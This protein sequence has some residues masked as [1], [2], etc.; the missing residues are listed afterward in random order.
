MKPIR[1]L[2]TTI[3]VILSLA[4][5]NA[6]TFTSNAAISVGNTTYDG[7]DII[8][9]GCTLTVDGPHAFA[10]LLV[11]HGGVLTHSSAPNGEANN[12]V[13]L[14]IVGNAT[15]DTTSSINVAGLGYA[16]NKGPGSGGQTNNGYAGG[17][18]AG[19]GG[20]ASPGSGGG[21]VYGSIPEPG[22]HGSGGNSQGGAGGGIIGLAVGGTLLVDGVISANG[23]HASGA[24]GGGGAGGSVLLSA[25]TLAGSGT[26]RADGGNSGNSSSGGGGG[27]RL[28]LLADTLSFSGNLSA[29]GG[30]GYQAGGAGTIFTRVTTQTNGR[31]RVDNAGRSGYTRVGAANWPT[32]QVYELSL[33]GAATVVVSLPITVPQLDI[34]GGAVLT[35]ERLCGQPLRITVL[36]QATISTGASINVDG[37]GYYNVAWNQLDC[38]PGVGGTT[39]TNGII[40]GGGYGGCGGLVPGITYGSYQEP[41][42]FGSTATYN[43]SYGG[44]SV[45]LAVAGTLTVDGSISAAGQTGGAGGSIFLTAATLAGSGSIHADGGNAINTSS[46][47][48]GGGRVALLA[49]A[50]SFS[51]SLTAIGGTGGPAGGAGTVYTRVTAQTYGQLS[52]DNAGRSGYT[53]LNTSIWPAGQVCALRIAGAAIVI[54]AMPITVSQLDITTG[55]MLTHERLGGQ[56]LRITVL[57]QATIGTGTSI[58]VDGAGYYSVSPSQ[59]DRGPGVGGTTGTNGVIGGGGYGGCGGLA[60]G[61]TYGTYQEPLEFGSAAVNNG[62]YGGG[63]VR[64]A[65][66]G[67]LTVDGSISAGGQVGGA[68]GSIFLTAATLAGGGAIRADGGNA[69]N[70]SSG[71]GG[72]GRVALLAD[73]LSFSGNLTAIGGTGGPAGGA[74]TVFTQVT[75]EAYGQLRLDNAGRSGYTRLNA[76]NWPAGQVC[77]LRIAGAAIVIPAMPISVSQLDIATGAMLTHERLA[78]QPLRITVLGSATIGSGA[79]INV[80]AAGYYYVGWWQYNRGPGAGGSTGTNGVNGGA[81]YG[82]LG[83]RAPGVT[84]GSYQEPLDF[85]SASYE[86]GSYGGGSVRL[87]VI[88]TLTVD[89]TV[90]ACGQGGGASGGSV[91][92]ACA[93]FAGGGI[94]Q[95]NGSAAGNT[96]SGGGGGGRIAI[97]S[98]TTS[99]LGS[100]SVTGGGGSSWP[101]GIGTIYLS[102]SVPP[103]FTSAA[104]PS[105]G[106]VGS[107]YNHTCTASGSTPITFTVSAGTLPTGLTLGT[108]GM[109]TGTPDASGTFSGT[110]TAAN[111]TLPNATQNFSIT[112]APAPTP[113]QFTS[114]PPPSSGMVGIA[115]NHTCTASGTSPITFTV[116]AGAL[117]TGLTMGTGGM[118]TGTPGTAGTFS[119]TI[120]AANG[121]QP[122][123]TQSF[124]ITIAPAPLAPQF[125]STA[126]PSSGMVGTAYNHTC[127]ASGSTPVTFSVSTGALPGGLILGTD[128]VIYGTP[129]ATG[130]FIGTITAA[131][132]TQPNATQSFSIT[133]EPAPI[134]PTIT[135]VSPLP[136]GTLGTAYTQTL[137][138]TG[139]TTPYTWTVT[140]GNLPLGLILDN[141]VITG[142]PNTAGSTTFSV[143]VKGSNGASSANDLSLTIQPASA[144]LRDLTVS[145]CVLTP[146]FTPEETSYTATTYAADLNVTP[147]TGNTGAAIAVRCN[148]GEWQPAVSGV[149]LDGLILHGGINTVETRVTAV[150]GTPIKTYAVTITRW[151]PLIAVSAGSNPLVDDAVAPLDFGPATSRRVATQTLTI[152]N[153]G[154]GE[155]ILGSLSNGGTNASDFTPSTPSSTTLAPGSST[156]LTITF[157][158][159]GS[160]TRTA[161]IHLASNVGGSTNPFDV[162]LTGMGLSYTN[163]TDGD[164]MS[165][166]AEYD[167]AALGFDWQANQ[168]ELV[169]TLYGG[170]NGAGLYTASQVET[171]SIG[172]PLLKRDPLSGQFKLTLGLS[173]TTNLTNFSFFPIA[174]PQVTINANGELELRFDSEDAAAFFR[175]EAK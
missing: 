125:T 6:T 64:L 51:G 157:N 139:G 169:A 130:T 94:I 40:G 152:S 56:P 171:L 101:G 15:V 70:T 154:T 1:K 20:N 21:A 38:G 10:S 91:Y 90:S 153:A 142:T 97:Y 111:G 55:A 44:G 93:E 166:A 72:G 28:A 136:T 110:I 95:A 133:I 23:N 35:H 127:T 58:N 50:L 155:L 149:S 103:Q 8:V 81:G 163:D 123:A 4:D 161:T 165:D 27:G 24:S 87:A 168:P 16:A 66:A 25:G 116:S 137:S 26:I 7:Q 39:G 9:Q 104:P 114:T 34:T 83:G 59:Y 106:M 61:A 19:N 53:R 78:G 42:E 147:T 102:T 131:N 85:G 122:N 31:L 79:S 3:A 71:G 48:G 37:A 150:G 124:S 120:T 144:D 107:A 119:G 17:G 135:T 60:L 47:G 145:G 96:S 126:P 172:T 148:S 65:V 77:A 100:K 174:A 13:G 5:A 164:G 86:N 73:T 57:G 82:G 158:P 76:S 41:L 45:R 49:D 143:Q 52:L 43:G 62:S 67:T 105:S 54:P 140:S 46:G 112:I 75:A 30:T 129:G 121:T 11:T 115:Y 117:P 108:G 12:R 175:V 162:T 88:G 134:P 113:P 63:S 29:I 128:G 22:T 36:G 170:A 89:G 173:K 14:T 84:Y 146:L 32:D 92:F 69:T 160:G 98:A 132:G 167:L 138:A 151:V 33:L 80:D 18:H 109:I 156:T 99:F 74:G 68:G 159:S 2:L 118:I 141:G